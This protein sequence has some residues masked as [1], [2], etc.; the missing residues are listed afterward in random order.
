MESY[1]RMCWGIVHVIKAF[2]PFVLAMA[3]ASLEIVNVLH[4][5]HPLDF[6][7][8]CQ[9]LLVDFSLTQIWNFR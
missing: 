1:F 8:P 6:S 9:N 3:L 7:F 5:L 4:A 2:G